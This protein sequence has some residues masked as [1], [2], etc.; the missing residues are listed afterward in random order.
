MK[1]IRLLMFILSEVREII[2]TLIF[3]LPGKSGK[4][5]RYIWVKIFIKNCASGVRFGRNVE[6]RSAK[7]LTLKQN[8]K[9]DDY[10][11][12]DATESSITISA[13]SMFN[14]NV[15][16]NASIGG[17][18][19]IGENCIIG[20][21]VIFRS[22][23]HKFEDIDIH[24]KNQGH[25]SSDIVIEDNVW[26]GASAIILPGVTIGNGCVVAAGSVV[27]K[28]FQASQVIGGVPARTIKKR[29]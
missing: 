21:G 3:A 14:R 2:S 26:I 8:V 13:N 11:F 28:S 24:I 18:I 12:L 22:A 4:A 16:I 7:N 17:E 20:P 1:I 9:F 27:T 15:Q 25:D 29:R 19:C 23:N 6:I 5:I 10:C